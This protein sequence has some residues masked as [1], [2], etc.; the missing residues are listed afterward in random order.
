MGC[1][2][3]AQ[4][5]AAA[6][7]ESAYESAWHEDYEGERSQ[8]EAV[9]N[10]PAGPEAARAMILLAEARGYAGEKEGAQA[11][12]E[13]VRT[14]YQDPELRA[15]ADLIG[16]LIVRETR[17]LAHGRRLYG[18]KQVCQQL[19]AEAAEK[20]RGTNLGG[21]ASLRL[22]GVLRSQLAQP[23]EALNVLEQ[24]AKDYAGTPFAEYALEDAAAV[25]SFSLKQPG[26]GRKRYEHLLATAHG[27]FV[28]QRAALHLGELYMEN[29][30]FR[31][32]Y[33]VFG[34]FVHTWPQHADSSGARVLL[35][36]VA[37]DL[38]HW[39]VAI[40]QA[41]ACLASAKAKFW[42]SR[43]HLILGRAAY[44]RGQYDLA[45]REFSLVVDDESLNS[46]GKAG[47]GYCLARRG[48]LRAAMV[49]FREAADLVA[50]RA[51]AP[52]YLYQAAS[53][54]AQLGDHSGFDSIAAQMTSEFPDSHLTTGLAE[55]RVAASAKAEGK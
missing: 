4:S 51:C 23:Q 5:A 15:F 45:Q 30:N 20:W 32:A 29:G 26:Q 18:G 10:G 52:Q 27:D 49:A 2:R 38:G 39:E 8:L 31:D 16:T 7:L 47:L 40:T 17:F 25:V 9:A 55:L 12:L 6:L 21:W 33:R 43:A 37:A 46:E 44:T 11:L 3:L 41:E 24:V 42:H 14:Q 28:R 48:D 54:A 35:A 36:Y 19:Y 50:N 1:T 13:R 53:L 34:R 22:A